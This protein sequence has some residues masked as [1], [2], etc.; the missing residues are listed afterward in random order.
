MMKPQKI[1]LAS[2]NAGKVKEFNLLLSPLG[3]EVITQGS[4]GID[5]CDEPFSTFIENAL[6]KARHAS[7]LSGLPALA[8]DSGICVQALQGMPG[9]KSARFAL[10]EKN[11]NPTDADNNHLLIEKLQG[12]SNRQAHFT[13][14]LVFL[15]SAQDPEPLIAVGQWNGQIIDEAQGSE[16]FGYDPHFL[17]SELN[18]TAAQM[19]AAEKN[20]VSHRGQALK[21]L[22][23]ALQKKYPQ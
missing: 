10:S 20:E 3:F 22:I 5:S 9:V 19:S 18:K 8:D 7:Q 23:N 2:N 11:T 13:C 6:A 1:V 15:E 21:L 17:I 12:L 4:L 16:G 14:T